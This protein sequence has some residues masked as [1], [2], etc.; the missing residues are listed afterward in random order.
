MSLAAPRRRGVVLPKGRRRPVDRRS[1]HRAVLG[2][3]GL[4]LLRRRGGAVAGVCTR[5]RPNTAEN[6]SPGS[7]KKAKKLPPGIGPRPSAGG[8]CRRTSFW[9]GRPLALGHRERLLQQ[10]VHPL[11]PRPRFSSTNR[12]RSSISCSRCSWRSFSLQCFWQRNLKSPFRDRF[13][14]IALAAELYAGLAGAGRGRGCC[15]PRA[16]PHNRPPRTGP[17]VYV[18]RQPGLVRQDRCRQ[19]SRLCCA[20]RLSH[21][22]ISGLFFLQENARLPSPHHP[23]AETLVF[24]GFLLPPLPL[25]IPQLRN[26]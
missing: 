13:T 15:V 10:H 5:W 2:R 19:P 7:G 22:A 14:L 25:P 8:S 12:R 1:A 23:P 26:R 24:P 11:G 3:R 16:A 21:R 4:H 18:A 9:R 17:R 6:G 20:V